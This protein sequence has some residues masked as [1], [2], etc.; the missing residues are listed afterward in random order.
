MPHRTK[1]LKIIEDLGRASSIVN[2]NALD[3][4]HHTA[5][6]AKEYHGEKIMSDETAQRIHAVFV[7][8]IEQGAYNF[9]QSRRHFTARYLYHRPAKELGIA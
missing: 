9:P 2:L 8:G 3:F 7:K 6:Y 1:L 4:L 5:Q